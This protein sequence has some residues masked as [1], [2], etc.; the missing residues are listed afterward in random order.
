MSLTA[1]P[2]AGYTFAGWS[3]A[4][5]DTGT[6][7]VVMDTSKTLTATFSAVP[8]NT[9]TVDKTG[10]GSVTSTPPGIDCGSTC[11]YTFSQGAS[12]RLTHLLQFAMQSGG[13][14]LIPHKAMPASAKS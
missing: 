9:L 2:G 5:T 6:C 10:I 3:G 7:T 11:S 4:C 1:A 14:L 13:N 8:T 12:V